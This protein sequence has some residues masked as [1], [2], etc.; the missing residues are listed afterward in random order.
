MDEPIID[1]IK[2]WAKFIVAE[3]VTDNIKQEAK[4]I[5][6]EPVTDIKQWAKFSG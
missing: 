5:V 2:W 3:S 6:A 4:F 1:N